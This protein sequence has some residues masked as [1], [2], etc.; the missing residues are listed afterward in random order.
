MKYSPVIHIGTH[1]ISQVSPTYFI[2][3][4]AA[5]HD[6][7]LTRAKELIHI[8]KDAGANAVKFQ[9]FKA[10]MIVSDRG[11]RDLGSQHSHQSKWSKPVFDVYRQYECHRDWT[12]ELVDTAKSA[13]VDFMTTP[14][15]VEEVQQLESYL[16]AF[17]IG[18][19]D[20]TWNQ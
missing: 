5:N 16:V 1:E 11:F 3:D 12:I 17:K 10:E 8:A 19:G 2:A 13:G 20:I 6:G 15:D 4:I 18:S 9:H 7:D 14:Y